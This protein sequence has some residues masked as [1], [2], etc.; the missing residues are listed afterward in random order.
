[1]TVAGSITAWIV[2]IA[3]WRT[4]IEPK[5]TSNRKLSE[6]LVWLMSSM[7]I[8]NHQKLT[9]WATHSQRCVGR[10]LHD[11]ALS[12]L[13]VVCRINALI[14]D[15]YQLALMKFFKRSALVYFIFFRSISRRLAWIMGILEYLMK[16]SVELKEWWRNTNQLAIVWIFFVSCCIWT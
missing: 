11:T 15:D 7:L 10:F 9:R 2:Y 8:D 12:T 4:T 16:S 3:V 13:T 14:F 6:H 5:Q 1:M